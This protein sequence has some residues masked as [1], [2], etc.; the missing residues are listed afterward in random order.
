MSD[1]F[2]ALVDS[3]AFVGFFVEQDAHFQRCRSAFQ[4]FA[5]SEKILVTTNL[6]VTETASMLSRR[7]T[8]A[9]ACQFIEFIRDGDFPLI[10]LD[11]TLQDSA[12]TIFLAQNREATSMV[13]C[14]NVAVSRYYSIPSILGFDAFYKKFGL[15]LVG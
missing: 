5:G 7:I 15:A 6:V 8:Y 13:D 3:D 4:A 10:Y 1:H 9:I 12:H 2:D 14:A 11:R